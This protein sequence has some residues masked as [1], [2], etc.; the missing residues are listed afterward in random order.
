MRCDRVASSCFV[1]DPLHRHVVVDRS[2][3]LVARRHT[4]EVEHA[5]L[6]RIEKKL[7]LRD[8]TR[9]QSQFKENYFL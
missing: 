7:I 4:E 6:S 1:R 9:V 5:G 8:I 2:V 3:S